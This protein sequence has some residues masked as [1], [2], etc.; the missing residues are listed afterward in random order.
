MLPA[1]DENEEKRKKKEETKKKVTTEHEFGQ[2]RNLSQGVAAA[3]AAVP[4]QGVVG[5]AADGT[6]TIEI[7]QLVA[8]G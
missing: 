8:G 6:T 7:L 4:A 2:A 5:G 1:K 3:S